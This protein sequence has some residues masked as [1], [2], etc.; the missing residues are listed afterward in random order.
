MDF[1]PTFIGL[2]EI[3][4]IWEDEDDLQHVQAHALIKP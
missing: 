2:E 4:G 3:V 1:R